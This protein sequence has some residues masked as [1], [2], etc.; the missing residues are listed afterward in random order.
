M[1][2]NGELDLTLHGDDNAQIIILTDN[3]PGISAE[4]MD[5]IFEPF[6]TTKSRGTGLGLS[7]VKQIIDYHHGK[8]D[9]WS[10]PG[11]GTKFTITLSQGARP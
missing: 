11:V 1:G 6:F 4:N 7:I 3:G 10:E 8:L 9:V 5:K 2:A